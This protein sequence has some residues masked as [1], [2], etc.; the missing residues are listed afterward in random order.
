MKS[1]NSTLIPEIRELGPD[2]SDEFVTLMEI[3]YKESIEQDRLDADE[4]R[5]I[6]KKIQ[7]PVYKV[8]SRVIGLRMEFY[9]ADIT[10]T[11]ASGVQLNIEKD[12]V[13]VGNIMTH[14]NFRRQGLA[15]KLIH[16]AFSRA[17]ELEVNKVRLDARADNVNAIGLYS[18]EGF[19]TTL[20]SGRFEL[21]SVIDD[22]ETNSNDLIVRK[23]NKIDTSVIDGMLDDCY[24]AS[25]LE[26]IG[27][28]KFLKE[29]IPS[30][31][32]RFFAGRLGGQMIHTYA[33]YNAGEE[34][35]SGIIQATQSKIEE[36]ILLSS[37]ILREKD[38]E[39]LLEVIPKILEIETTYRGINRAS[40]NCSMH[41]T[42]AISKIESLGFKKLREI[43]SMT[44]QL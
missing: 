2:E 39:M 6:L 18:S 8:I 14:P 13:H 35:P 41:R 17:R 23:V 4:L 1:K 37:P 40:I 30:R 3:S 11:I 22:T 15:R 26:S 31:A 44:R 16:L 27:R 24:P 9:A 21:E 42:D 29:F 32:I 5:K 38:N 10:G 34:T 33:F 36:R 7:T 19:E 20:H 28:K 12:V 43:I 25:Y